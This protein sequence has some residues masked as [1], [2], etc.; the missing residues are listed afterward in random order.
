M[1]KLYCIVYLVLFVVIA[2][3]WAYSLC[4]ESDPV[5]QVSLFVMGI[6]LAIAS[7]LFANE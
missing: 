1:R 2:I 3:A 7:A 6:V 4:T 5:M